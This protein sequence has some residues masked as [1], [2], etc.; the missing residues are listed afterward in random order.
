MEHSIL[1]VAELVKALEK[2]SEFNEYTNCVRKNILRI[3]ESC[4]Y[5]GY[6]GK[7][8]DFSRIGDRHRTSLGHFLNKGKWDSLALEKGLRKSVAEQ[9][10]QH[11]KETGLPIMCIIDDTISSKT[12]PS[13]RAEHPMEGTS[14][15]MSH[16]KRHID[17]GHQA[18]GVMLSCGELIL[19]YAIIMYDKGKS[20]IDLV[21]EIAD[22]L[23][24]PPNEGYLLCDGWYP[25]K[26]V[27]DQYIQKGFYTIA[28]LKTNRILY[29]SGIRAKLSV[30]AS[31]LLKI[32]PSVR[33]IS[34]CKKKY[35]IYR[36]DGQIN[37]AEDVSVILS[38]PEKAF[39]NPKALRAFLCTNSALSEEEILNLYTKRWPIE[40]FFRTTKGKLALDKY[41]IR[42]KN[43]ICRFWILM[44][45]THYLCCTGKE[46]LC[47]FT[48]GFRLWQNTI[49]NHFVQYI[50]QCG[51]AGIPVP[52]LGIG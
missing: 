41:Q 36:Y 2:I 52:E 11:S 19:N 15:H 5:D 42:S 33:K 25:C 51:A 30:F 34:V 13:S 28:G 35:W 20:K 8:V 32:G 14:N 10:Y 43:G 3:V 4:F 44:S 16:L 27:M 50:F 12:R 9:V 37:G 48:E 23:P 29:P 39:G 17:Y 7:T 24:E 21:C 22:E 6:S 47:S 18:I 31:K 45:L 40:V 46:V 38:Y 1:Y 49:Q 26:K